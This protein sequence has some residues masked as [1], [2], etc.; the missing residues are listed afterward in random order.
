MSEL[1]IFSEIAG[2]NFFLFETMQDPKQL[3]MTNH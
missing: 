2:D 1:A 3:F